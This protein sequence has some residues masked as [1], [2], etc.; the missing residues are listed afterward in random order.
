[1]Q[2]SGVLPEHRRKGLYS[3]L[4]KRV[5]NVA[6]GLGFQDIWS[7]HNTTNNAVIIPKLKQGFLITGIEVTDIFGTLI[8]LH[9]YP[10]EIRRRMTDYRVGQ[11]K[12]DAEI[13]KYLG[14]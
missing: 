5:V 1:M 4:V 13:K 8:H 7:R 9:Y 2:N 11:I 12:P 14:I 10:K 3:E 6:T